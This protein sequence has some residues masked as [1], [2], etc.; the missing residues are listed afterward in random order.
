MSDPTFW[1]AARSTGIVAYLLLTAV[2][3]MGA[4]LSGRGRVRGL[5]AGDINEAHRYTALLALVMTAA[6]GVALVL[7]RAVDIPLA[8]LVVPGLVPYRP[9][10]TSAGVLAGWLALALYT[11]FSARK[12]IGP[13]VWRRLHYAAY[14]AFTL[15][16][17]H[18]LAAGTDSGST[19][20]L[21]L[22]GGSVGAVVGATVWR[23]G[24][25]RKSARARRTAARVG[26]A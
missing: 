6:H 20:A 25:E 14:G 5:S 3:L 18:G 1:I 24:V 2:M 16:A 9:V 15:A 4:T 12:M 10:W 21:A 26:T 8:G 11:S 13:R 7:D 23:A 17:V 19:W 22:Y